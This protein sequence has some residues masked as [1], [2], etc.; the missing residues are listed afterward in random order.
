VPQKPKVIWLVGERQFP[1][2]EVD[3]RQE[4][5][6][7]DLGLSGATNTLVERWLQLV[8]DDREERHDE[9]V[10]TGVRAAAALA[11]EFGFTVRVNLAMRDPRVGEWFS[12]DTRNPGDGQW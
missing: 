12:V 3:D 6:L 4:I 7:L 9:A 11:R 2:I 10:L 8:R 1:A 5:D